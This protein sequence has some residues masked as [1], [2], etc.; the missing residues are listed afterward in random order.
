MSNS[1]RSDNPFSLITQKPIHQVLLQIPSSTLY[2][3]CFLHFAADITRI[4]SLYSFSLLF[5][6][7]FQTRLPHWTAGRRPAGN[8]PHE[9]RWDEKGKNNNGIV[10]IWNSQQTGSYSGLLWENTLQE[11][12]I[13]KPVLLTDAWAWPHFLNYLLFSM[14]SHP[15]HKLSGFTSW[16]IPGQ[17][18]YFCSY[19]YPYRV[20]LITY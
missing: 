10:F 19:R 20:F 6:Q 15:N 3:C 16:Q 17:G 2:K 11:L 5:L 18:I 7:C 12:F 8:P 1:L 9:R 4:N 13:P 14:I